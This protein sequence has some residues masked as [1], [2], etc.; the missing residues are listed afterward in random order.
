ENALF[1]RKEVAGTIE[2]EITPS[3]VDT[4]KTLSEKFKVPEGNIKI[5]GINGK[6]GSK[7]FQIEAN[8]YSSEEEKDKTEL[9]KKKDAPAPVKQEEAKPE[10]AEP[11]KEGE[12]PSEPA[13]EEPKEEE[14]PVEE[15]KPEET[16]DEAAK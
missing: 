1:G 7:T 11:P 16:K 12:A 13:K 8:I 10:A 4:L 2:S 15:S 3:R 14:K 9:K 5:K 6:F